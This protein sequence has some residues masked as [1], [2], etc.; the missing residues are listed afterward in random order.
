MNSAIFAGA[1]P[2]T[3]LSHTSLF[4]CTIYLIFSDACLIFCERFRNRCDT[5]CQ[6]FDNHPGFRSIHRIVFV[7]HFICCIVVCKV[8]NVRCRG[9]E[10]RCKGWE[11]LRKV[12]E[13]HR[14]TGETFCNVPTESL[15]KMF[16]SPITGI[17][18]RKKTILTPRTWCE[19]PGKFWL[20]PFFLIVTPV[21]YSS[22][23]CITILKTEILWTEFLFTRMKCL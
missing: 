8:C 13:M 18:T 7:I 1:L 10:M 3:T 23:Y 6:R 4:F 17:I 21:L 19:S 22:H 12:Q 5:F 9:W 2:W 16:D 15:C 11:V 14:N 20:Y